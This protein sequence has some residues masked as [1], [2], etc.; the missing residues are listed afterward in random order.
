VD[1]AKSAGT[2][3]R[4]LSLSTKIARGEKLDPAETVW[5]KRYGLIN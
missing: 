2:G 1:V 5:A 4:A 3:P